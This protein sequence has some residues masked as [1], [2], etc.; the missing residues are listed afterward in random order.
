MIQKE[1]KFIWNEPDIGPYDIDRPI[2]VQTKQDKL[3]AF[4]DTQSYENGD[5]SEP[6]SVW[7]WMVNKYK[8]KYW[9]YQS[10]ITEYDQLDYEG[11]WDD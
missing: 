8:I 10:A 5:L 2:L 1:I 3:I 6:I 9:C 11:Y 7:K 4:N